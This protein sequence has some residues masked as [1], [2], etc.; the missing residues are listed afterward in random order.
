VDRRAAIRPA[1]PSYRFVILGTVWASYLI[2][3]LS[4]L[5][6]G[7]LAPFLKDAFDLSNAEVGSLMSAT[8]VTYAPAMIAAGLLVDR[9]G[10]KRVLVPGTLLA[11][12]CVGLL[13][14]APSYPVLLMLLA[15]SGI[16]CG[17]I[18]P[19]A[20]KALV[21]WFPP[22]ERATAIGLNQSAINVSGIAG[23]AVLPTVALAMGWQ[24]GFLFVGLLALAITV[25]CFVLY[26][27]PAGQPLRPRN[28]GEPLR[29]LGRHAVTGT[30]ESLRPLGRHAVT[31]AGVDAGV[32]AGVV[33]G[34]GAG[35][36]EGVGARV[37]AAHTGEAGR[38]PF[39]GGVDDGVA[40]RHD[41]SG[42][43]G[44]LALLRRRDIWLLAAGGLFLGIVEFSALA[45]MVLYL[46]ESLAYTAV[47]AGGLLAVCEAA[48]AFGKPG[49]GLV[50]D[51]L[52]R[53]R[54]KPA[55]L[56]LA[57]AA[58]AVCAVFAVSGGDLGWLL[59]PCLAV[60]GV[61]A[62]GW[63]GLYGTMA[64]EIGGARRAGLAAG[65]C[66]AMVN[67]G[68]VVGP[69]AFGLLVDRT[70]SYR[71]SWVLLAAS[72]GI[73][74]VC[75][76][77]LRAPAATKATAGATAVGPAAAGTTRAQPVATGRP[78]VAYDGA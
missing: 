29:P 12:L 16:G 45:H 73:A 56:A 77:L 37:V 31:G 60:F 24:Y 62:I 5:S 4:R 65:L 18:Y 27:E 71:A 14:V 68:I 19:S 13:F 20:V 59:Y 58:F 48:G 46:K 70:G 11:G 42:W 8:A 66:S 53:G 22:R 61:A 33:E 34:V 78:G 17:C 69:P 43:A 39:D 15:L 41:E 9:I 7:P 49:S 10:V 1:G 44:V 54:R 47:A 6:V 74:V 64:G 52:F 40:A 55:L 32:G 51:R 23:A 57:I 25:V 2:V 26:R 3:Y 72:A 50:S 30:G 63:A 21:T 67:V 75:W 76:S 35:V 36:V 38:A 28:P